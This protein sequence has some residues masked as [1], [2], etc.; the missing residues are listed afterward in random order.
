MKWSS[1]RFLNRQTL[2][3]ASA[4]CLVFGHLVLLNRNLAWLFDAI[5]LK[6]VPTTWWTIF[7][8]DTVVRLSA[9]YLS[10]VALSLAVLLATVAMPKYVRTWSSR[11]H[12]LTNDQ[13]F[14]LYPTEEH[15]L[16]D[17]VPRIRRVRY[18]SSR[19]LKNAYESLKSAKGD[20]DSY[21]AQAQKVKLA[22]FDLVDRSYILAPIVW[23]LFVTSIVL[24]GVISLSMFA[25]VVTFLCQEIA[26]AIGG[27]S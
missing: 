22:S 17:L 9:L 13:F 20:N 25:S 2:L 23:I 10:G 14:A 27:P 11:D 18:W 6:R 5:Q 7:Q 19:R 3:I 12:S 16:A 24:S 26:S 15:L 8:Q 1:L 4:S 21:G